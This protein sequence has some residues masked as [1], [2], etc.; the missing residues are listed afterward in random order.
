M[1]ALRACSV[2]FLSVPWLLFTATWLRPG[3]AIV[4]LGLHAYMLFSYATHGLVEPAD[5]GDAVLTTTDRVGVRALLFIAVLAIAWT[6]FSGAGG[7][8]FQNQ[9]DWNNKNALMRDLLRFDWPVG[10]E[11]GRVL[12]Y[13]FAL[14]LPASIVGRLAGWDAAQWVLYA[15]VLIGVLLTLLWLY[16]FS[17]RLGVSAI[18]LFMAF[19]G[20]DIVGYL[21]MRQHMPAKGG[22]I[23]WWAQSM[24]FSGNTTLLFWVPQHCLPA[25]IL[26]AL[27]LDEVARFRRVVYTGFFVALCLLWSPFVSAG[28]IPIA[29]GALFM[30]NGKGLRSVANFVY[31]PVMS[32]F[33]FALYS[34]HKDGSHVNAP[35]SY[36]KAHYSLAGLRTM[37]VFLALEVGVYVFFVLG[38]W[39]RLDRYWRVLARVVALAAVLWV[40]VPDRV[41]HGG[42]NMRASA[43][44]LFVLFLL[45]LHVLTVE[46]HA[47]RRIA[48]AAC[49]MLGSVAGLQEVVRS[50]SRYPSHVPEPP[51]ATGVLGL[52][53]K[54]MNEL[55]MPL[56]SRLYRLL[57]R[58]PNSV[59]HKEPVLPTH[60]SVGHGAVHL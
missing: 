27:V 18:L 28:L 43:P 53:T 47:V 1:P 37:A 45:V 36:W 40:L 50:A 19:G 41:G 46:T 25:W 44:A 30:A 23:E 59:A 6:S 48:L 29:V 24:Q 3:W 42:F 39:S 31:L 16:S 10:Y 12:N 57:F 20:L 32:A 26:T 51:P 56:D 5:R 34:P 7:V 17:G 21:L 35:L 54:N 13:Y 38:C 22:G 9:P 58:A 2:A 11:N 55:V 60:A 4:L 8:G 14:Y 52:G 49:L 33:A 15:E